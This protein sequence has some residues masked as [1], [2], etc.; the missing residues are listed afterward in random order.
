MFFS[1]LLLASTALFGFGT[2]GGTLLGATETDGLAVDFTASTPDLLIRDAAS[3]LNYSG[4]PFLNDGGKL[5][6]SRTSLAT[7]VDDDGLIKW[8]PHNILLQ[9]NTFSTTWTNASST[10]TAAAGV[11]P[12][13]TTTAWKLV[14]TATTGRISQGGVPS[15]ANTASVVDLTTGS[16][17]FNI[18]GTWTSL[19]TSALSNGWF[20]IIAVKT[21]AGGEVYTYSFYAKNAGYNYAM[22]QW[23]STNVLI[24]PYVEEDAAGTPNGTDG[25]FIWGAHLY[26]SDLG[27]MQDNGT[28]F[29][30]YNPTTTAAYYGPR[31][32][33]DPVTLAKRGLLMEEQRVNLCLHSDDLTNAAWVKT[34]ATAAKTAIGPDGVANSASTLT[35]TAAHGHARQDITSA[36]AQRVTSIYAK[37]RTGTGDVTLSQGDTTGS[38]LVTNGTFTTDLS[39]WTDASIGT[40]SATWDATSGGRVAIYR[41]DANNA[42]VIRQQLTTVAGKT[43]RFL[44]TKS[45]STATCRVGTAANGATLLSATT[46]ADA[47]NYFSFVATSTSSFIQVNTTEN[48]GTAYMD[49]ISVLEVAETTIS[50]TSDWQRLPTAAATITN[51]DIIIKLA[52]SGDAIDVYGVQNETGAFATSLIPTTTASVTRA[53]D[54]NT[55]ANSLFPY[56]ATEGTLYA[57]VTPFNVAAARRAIQMDDGTANERV[58]LGT[59]ATPNGLFTVIDGGV[60]QA[61][62]AT[63]TPAA[64]T[65]IKLAA[66]WTADD[67]A[68]SVDGAAA[69][70]DT[71][72][73]IPTMTTLRFGSGPSAAEPLNGHIRK[74]VAL[75]RAMSD[76]ELATRST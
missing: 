47:V 43:Y 13:G 73:T 46:L 75:P 28:A 40:G 66:S 1:N 38:E 67:F 41:F 44:V 27:G 15:S 8:A 25:I 48:G 59:D 30:T 58:T 26:R 33:H 4:T 19:T 12:D 9:S 74:I 22:V 54:A 65:T 36:S 16:V 14:A 7:V 3:T 37:R 29:P 63:G 34:S 49:D 42:G 55:A 62:I 69:E 50:L 70:V 45:G 20:R 52:T 60:S 68:L 6:F 31:I 32:D 18:T 11:A 56:S 57:E 53:A 51:P 39:G 2:A 5:T 71:S 23:N 10:E 72:G 17:T 61:A 24:Y 21:L 35:A 76:A 64:N